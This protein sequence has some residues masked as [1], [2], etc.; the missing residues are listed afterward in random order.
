V[1]ERTQARPFIACV[2]VAARRGAKTRG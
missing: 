2:P 1:I